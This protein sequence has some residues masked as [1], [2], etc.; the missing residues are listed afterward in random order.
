MSET[1]PN[2]IV[3][4]PAVKAAQQRRGSREMYARM[5]ERGQFPSAID[6]KLAD[7]VANRDSFY[8]GTA[9]RDGQPYIQ[10]RGGPK[11]FLKVLDEHRL[12]FGDIAGNSQYISIGNLDENNRAFIFLMDYP[13]RR[14]IKFWGT[15]EVVEDDPQLLQRV[16]MPN[17]TPERVFVFHVEAWNAN[18]PKNIQQRWTAEEV[19]ERLLELTTEVEQLKRENRALRRQISVATSENVE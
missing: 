17:E 13:N 11:G 7:F 8:L 15:A 4:T 6:Q 5:E 9:S 18:C 16:S 14:R 1:R 12:A 2:D 10:H 19:D 3:F